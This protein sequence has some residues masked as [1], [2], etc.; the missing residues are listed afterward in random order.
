ML[1]GVRANVVVP[2][3]GTAYV[4]PP[5]LSLPFASNNLGGGLGAYRLSL[6]VPAGLLVGGQFSMQGWLL[7]STL[8]SHTGGLQVT[9]GI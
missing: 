6:K 7:E 1:I 8:L 9:L 4:F 3:L 5:V 2:G